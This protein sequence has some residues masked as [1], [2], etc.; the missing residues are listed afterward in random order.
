MRI[1]DGSI[2]TPDGWRRG[3]LQFG[4]TIGAVDGEATTVPSPPFIVPGFI[5]LHVHGGGGADVMQGEAAVR[6]MAST[7]ARHGTTAL[8]ATTVTSP[9]TAIDAALDGIAAVVER[10]DDDEAVVLGAHLEGPFLNPD[11]L[12]AQPPFAIAPDLGLFATWL[13]RAPVRV[14]TYAPECDQDDALARALRVAGVRAQVGHS[15]ADAATAAQVFQD[16]AGATHLFNA[17]SGFDHRAP[18]VTGAALAHAKHAEIIC[19]LVH[20]DATAIL[21]A[22]RAISGLYVVTDATAGAAMPDGD[23]PLGTQV[24]HK[25]DGVLRLADG[26]LAGSS[27]TMDQA[28]RNLV[29]MGL[30]LHE[31]VRRLTEIP[32]AWLG[33]NDRGRIAPGARADVVVL[34]EDLCVAQVWIGGQRIDRRD[35][36]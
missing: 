13:R 23:Y 10:P 17:M 34:D 4:T 11:K 27:L 12:G 32:A 21:A 31:T 24:A 26:N 3:N 5:D 20:V 29:A 25:R 2:L 8:L 35:G 28:L 1:L 36:L 14:M 9:A 30:P 33:L 7:H 15:L 16:G 19:D 22:R 18:G 6:T